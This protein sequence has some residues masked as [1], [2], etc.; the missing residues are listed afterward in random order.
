MTAKNLPASID[1]TVDLEAQVARDFHQRVAVGGMQPAA[2]QV[3]RIALMNRRPGPAANARPRF[4]AAIQILS[5][6]GLRRDEGRARK[7]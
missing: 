7:T 2:A 3:E 6:A 1:A 5:E 4:Q